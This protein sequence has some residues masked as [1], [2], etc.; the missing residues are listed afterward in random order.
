M[1]RVLAAVAG[2]A[3]RA[4]G[5]SAFAAAKKPTASRKAKAPAR[6]RGMWVRH[7]S[8]M[9]GDA[10]A[11][12]PA[13]NR[14]FPYVFVVVSGFASRAPSSA[15]LLLPSLRYTRARSASTVLGLMKSWAATFRF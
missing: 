5:A 7:F 8:A 4:R 2:V 10:I 13:R 1:V 14:V 15:R 3:V 11:T 9:T 6:R 12:A